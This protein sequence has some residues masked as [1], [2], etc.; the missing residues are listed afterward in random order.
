MDEILCKVNESYFALENL[1]V[2]FKFLE[3]LSECCLYIIEEGY[4]CHFAGK[5]S[6]RDLNGFK[7]ND[8]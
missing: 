7:A 4:L 6:E 3:T 1:T 5:L 8:S 2:L